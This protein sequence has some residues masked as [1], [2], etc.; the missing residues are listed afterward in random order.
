MKL[1]LSTAKKTK[2]T[3]FSRV[4][5]PKKIDKFLG[6]SKLNFWTKNEEFEQCAFEFNLPSFSSSETFCQV[7]G[8]GLVS[9]ELILLSGKIGSY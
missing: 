4:F 8:Y 2:T 1:K 9:A 3:T 6:K 7:N 5:H